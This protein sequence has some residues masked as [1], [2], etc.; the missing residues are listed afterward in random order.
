MNQVKHLKSAASPWRQGRLGAA[1]KAAKRQRGSEDATIAEEAHKVVG[2]LETYATERLK[3]LE[4]SKL[5]AP[6]AAPK[7]LVQ[8]ARR[9]SGSDLGKKLAATARDWVKDPDL[10]QARKA[11][12]LLTSLQKTASAV[13]G[14]GTLSDPAVAR[15]YAREIAI[16]TILTERLVKDYPKTPSCDYARTLLKNLGIPMKE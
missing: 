13:R 4:A 9:Y 6:T 8:L 14:K 16:M 2:A 1:L 11:L 5:T 7:A 3:A 10:I 12:P 15:R